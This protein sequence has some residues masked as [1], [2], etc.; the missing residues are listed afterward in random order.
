MGKS[1]LLV[2]PWRLR[3]E[4]FLFL[5]AYVAMLHF[6]SPD[7]IAGPDGMEDDS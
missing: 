4:P 6:M 1:F 5:N 3:L 7:E 2:H